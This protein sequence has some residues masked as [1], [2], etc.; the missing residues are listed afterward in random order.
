LEARSPF[1]DHRLVE[2]AFNLS[3]KVKI[4]EV[5]TKPILR[6]MARKYLPKEIARAPKRGFE[7]PLITWLRE[8][9]SEMVHDVCLSSK[10]II[11][12]L[13]RRKYVEDLLSERLALD[14][15]RWANRVWILFVLGMWDHFNENRPSRS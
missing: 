10:S 2:Y 5:Q 13:F 8:Y 7:I 3:P 6:R 4:S 11:L 1:L 14:P 9:F 12:E 15:A